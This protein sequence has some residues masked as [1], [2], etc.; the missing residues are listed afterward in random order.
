M[1]YA[2]RIA[3]CCRN[4]IGKFEKYQYLARV[5]ASLDLPLKVVHN[6]P[7]L[8]NVLFDTEGHP[9]QHYRSRHGNARLTST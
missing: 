5:M 3:H 2:E 1:E 8:S 9:M 4:E 7:K 6:D